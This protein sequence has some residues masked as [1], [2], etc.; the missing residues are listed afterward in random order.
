MY[1]KHFVSSTGVQSFM[2][3]IPTMRVH[4]SAPM[5]SSQVLGI[6]KKQ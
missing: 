5:R 3:N 1:K 4:K 2:N 6:P